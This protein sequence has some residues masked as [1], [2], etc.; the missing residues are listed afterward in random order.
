MKFQ[1]RVN[2]VLVIIRARIVT[3]LVKATAHLVMSQM[4]LTEFWQMEANV[5]VYLG[6]SISRTILL[7]YL[8]IILAEI[9]M[10]LIL[11]I[12]LNVW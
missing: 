3:V 8:A 11:M 2:V 10:D 7:V 9:V 4:K 1:I 6:T 12:A 5:L